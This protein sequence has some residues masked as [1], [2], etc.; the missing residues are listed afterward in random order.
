MT[1]DRFCKKFVL[2]AIIA[3]IVK[4]TSTQ[5]SPLASLNRS[6]R[7][8]N[9]IF[10]YLSKKKKEKILNVLKESA[11]CNFSKKIS[12]QQDKYRVKI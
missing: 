7:R 12:M 6:S 9:E 1:I 10:S 5:Q 11:T 3:I 4:K 2:V 8:V